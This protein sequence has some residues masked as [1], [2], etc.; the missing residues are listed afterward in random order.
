MKKIGY[1]LWLGMILL[2]ASVLILL[3]LFQIVFLN[4]FYTDLKIKGLMEEGETVISGLEEY[5]TLEDAVFDSTLQNSMEELA[6]RQQLTLEIINLSRKALYKT[7]SDTGMMGRGIMLNANNEVYE[8]ALSGKTAKIKTQHPRFGTDYML[9]GLPI[10]ENG[11]V[12]GV[13][14][15]NAALAP[16]EDTAEILKKQ[17]V[18]ITLGLLIISVLISYFLSKSFTRPILRL[19]RVAEAYSRGDFNSRA[20]V[21]R[22]DELGQLA[23]RINRMGEELAKNEQ[24]RKDLIANV[25]HELRTPLSLIR[26]YAETLRDVTGDNPQKRDKQLGVII[27][28]T[29][30]PIQACGRYPCAVTI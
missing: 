13:M 17:L 6:Y 8:I 26:G 14:I 16:V 21:D 9:I 7:D 5:D 15:L 24:L 1:K 4:R 27:E 29:D 19:H 12:A 30:R 11:T 10:Y 18:W 23:R 25:S 22:R 3:W 2:A 20:E 28:E